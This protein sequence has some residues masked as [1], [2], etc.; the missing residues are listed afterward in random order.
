V[1]AGGGFAAMAWELAK[2]RI[3]VRIN[4]PDYNAGG[5]DGPVPRPNPNRLNALPESYYP[6]SAEYYRIIDSATASWPA[7]AG[8]R[9]C[10]ICPRVCL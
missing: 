9:S 4:M 3:R 1:I 7:F 10:G 6:A 5:V 2:Q 8:E